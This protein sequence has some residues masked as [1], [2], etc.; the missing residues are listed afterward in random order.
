MTNEV[1][2]TVR[3]G[4]RGSKLSLWQARWV[5]MRLA[6]A[7]PGRRIEIVPIVTR[8]DVDQQPF[9]ELTESGVFTSEI[10]L[11]LADG[12]IDL[13]VHSL[14]DLPVSGMGAPAVAAVPVR[15]DAADALVSREGFTLTSL[16]RGACV[17]TSSPRRTSLVRALRPDLEI[18]PVRGNVDTRVRKVDDGE[19]DAILLAVAG[20]ERLGLSARISERLDPRVFPPAP[21]Q[22]ALAIQVGPADATVRA[23]VESMDDL[24]A[25]AAV[26]A[27]RECLRALG[28]G[29]SRPVGAYAAW[30]GDELE[31]T[32]VVGSVDGA[33][34]FEETSSG[35]DARELG[36]RVAARLIAAGAGELLA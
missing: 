35:A 25:H 30:S 3:L 34:L 29:C 4:T 36:E 22:G 10:E 12:R 13:A 21:G 26:T 17:G 9:T 2:A 1:G 32:A 24:R 6:S 23:A 18:S 27:E 7:L 33:T 20:L 28:G 31:L 14:K 15:A 5:A 8:G 16:P 11:A 19:Y